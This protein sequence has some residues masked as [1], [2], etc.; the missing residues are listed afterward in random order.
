MLLFCIPE[1]LG[2]DW[3]VRLRI[4]LGLEP[5][6]WTLYLVVLSAGFVFTRNSAPA[7]FMLVH[8]ASGQENAHVCDARL[9]GCPPPNPQSLGQT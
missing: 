4:A 8:G 9:A 5:K 1:W 2:K 3:Q 7:N 6:C